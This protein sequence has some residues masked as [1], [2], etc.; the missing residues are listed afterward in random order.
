M[1]LVF[2]LVMAE[3]KALVVCAL[4]SGKEVLKWVCSALIRINEVNCTMC[5]LKIMLKVCTKTKTQVL[6][7]KMFWCF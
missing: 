5:S 6:A 4:Y 2:S 7:C 1:R 3:K